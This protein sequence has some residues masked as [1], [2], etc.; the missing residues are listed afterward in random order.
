MSWGPQYSMQKTDLRAPIYLSMQQ[1]YRHKEASIISKETDLRVPHILCE[2]TDL[3][4]S[5]YSMLRNG[6]EWGPI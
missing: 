6:P 1:K 2:E 3:R 4:E 5:P